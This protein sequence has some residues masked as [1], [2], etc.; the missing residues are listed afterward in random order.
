MWAGITFREQTT[1]VRLRWKECS[2]TKE[3]FAYEVKENFGCPYLEE[4]LCLLRITF[5]YIYE[6]IDCKSANCEMIA[7]S[8]YLHVDQSR[9]ATSVAGGGVNA[10]VPLTR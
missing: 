2:A 8:F 7:Q 3:A 1:S 4:S 10:A 6:H 5:C 9:G